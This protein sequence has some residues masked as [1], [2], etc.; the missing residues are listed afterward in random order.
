MSASSST[1][2]AR[3]PDARARS[4]APLWVL[5]VFVFFLGGGGFGFKK[6]LRGHKSFLWSHWNPVVDTS[7][8][9]T[10]YEVW[11]KVM[12]S[13]V[14]VCSKGEGLL[15]EG[16][17]SGLGGGGLVLCE[18]FLFFWFW[19]CGLFFLEKNFGGHK[20]FLWDPLFFGLLIKSSL[21]FKARVGSLIHTWCRDH[22]LHVPWDLPFVLHLLTSWW[23]GWQLSP[24]SSTYLW[25]GIGGARSRD[26]SCCHCCLTV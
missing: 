10:A 20:S 1:T 19:L 26:L 15:P 6:N 14:F 17:M 12:F 16:W 22:V 21:G 7:F 8:Y 2:A 23:P 9:R 25:A 3:A 5:L 11:G 18:Y 4:S 24:S 13:R